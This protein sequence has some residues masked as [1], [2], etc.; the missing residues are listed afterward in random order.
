M[1][2]RFKMIIPPGEVEAMQL[3]PENIQ[4]A[5]TWSG[6]IQVVQGDPFDGTLKFTAINIPTEREGAV[7]AEPYWWVIKHNDGHFETMGPE[8]FA[9]TYERVE[10]DDG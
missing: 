9:A 7:R 5:E 1:P 10:G 2:R 4:K 6:G 8:E 3:T